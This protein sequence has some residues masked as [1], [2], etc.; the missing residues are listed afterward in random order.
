MTESTPAFPP[1]TEAER[2]FHLEEY[3]GLRAEIA[4]EKKVFI[5]FFVYAVVASAAV[6]TWLFTHKAELGPYGAIVSR[7]AAAIPLAATLLAFYIAWSTSRNLIGA[8]GRYCALLERRIAASGLGWET[9]LRQPSERV[10]ATVPRR[11]LT[12]WASLIA[13]DLVVLILV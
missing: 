3:K 8:L 13:A 6:S 4:Y 10:V 5:D 7:A 12:G 11:M 2:A 1:L 9:F